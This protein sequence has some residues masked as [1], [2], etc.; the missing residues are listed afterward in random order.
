[1]GGD[2]GGGE[3]QRVT[4]GSRKR[5][6]TSLQQVLFLFC[7][8]LWLS[9]LKVHEGCALTLPRG[10]GK[11]WWE[12]MEEEADIIETDRINLVL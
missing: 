3:M 1:M 10:R 12:M 9:I 11:A 6:K 8:S 7:L 5:K 4:S 2:G